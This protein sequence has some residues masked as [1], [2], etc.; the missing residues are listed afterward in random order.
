MKTGQGAGMFAGPPGRIRI[1][2]LLVFVVGMVAA[3]AVYLFTPPSHADDSA[4]SWQIVGGQTF[5]GDEGNARDDQQLARIG[6]Q[7]AVFAV[8]FNRWLASLWHGRRLAWTLA[9][10]A[11]AVAALCFHIAALMAEPLDD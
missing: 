7:A 6:G 4:T 9:L 10:L 3:L 11:A 1:G 5:T 2:G 8:T